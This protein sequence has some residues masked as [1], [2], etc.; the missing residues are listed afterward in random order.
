MEAGIQEWGWT[1][2]TGIGVTESFHKLPCRSVE[3]PGNRDSEERQVPT[4]GLP[5]GPDEAGKLEWEYRK[6]HEV[7]ASLACAMAN[8]RECFLFLGPEIKG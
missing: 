3:S 8:G 7:P 1:T 6:E 2:R 5:Q 4:G